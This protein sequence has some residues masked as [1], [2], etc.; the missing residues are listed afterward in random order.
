M[1]LITAV[2]RVE[3]TGKRAKLADNLQMALYRKS[4][5]ASEAV[6]YFIANT[7]QTYVNGDGLADAA[8]RCLFSSDI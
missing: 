3:D 7:V 2:A 6:E 5:T 8:T 4:D 1:T